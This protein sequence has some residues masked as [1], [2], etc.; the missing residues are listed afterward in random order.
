MLAS[1][2][3]N[4]KTLSER[5]AY[6][7]GKPFICYGTQNKIKS[8]IPLNAILFVVEMNN[9][10]NQIVGIGL[11]RNYISADKH[12]IYEDQNYHR[13]V[14]LGKYRI[15]REEMEEKDEEMVKLFDLIL[16]KGY[17]HI[18]RQTGITIISQKLLC[19]DRLR[20]ANLLERVKEL[21][22][23]KYLK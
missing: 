20:G 12:F 9:E 6:M 8:T 18:K 17:T 15:T 11:I 10:K 13:Y 3:F 23:N 7:D 4:E 22:K 21:F 19:D 14:Y 5:N 1:T 2:R 16:F